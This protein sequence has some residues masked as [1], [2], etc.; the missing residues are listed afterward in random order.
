MDYVFIFK[1]KLFERTVDQQLKKFNE[2][3]YREGIDNERD[4]DKKR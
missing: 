1:M 4:Y 2:G 3:N